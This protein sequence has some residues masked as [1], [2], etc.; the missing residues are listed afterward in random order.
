M[1]GCFQ[2]LSLCLSAL[3]FTMSRD[4]LAIELDDFSVRLILRLLDA[5]SGCYG[6]VND[7][8][9]ER[10]RLKVSDICT[11]TIHSSKTP[12]VK[13]KPCDMTVCTF[14][15]SLIC[16]LCCLFLFTQIISVCMYLH[17][18]AVPFNP[19]KVA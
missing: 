5:D 12:H 1:F 7:D 10:I 3:L 14:N 18:S 2:S 11:A 13:L 9:L 6:N 19:L 8:E 17:I 16:L 15:F 4:R